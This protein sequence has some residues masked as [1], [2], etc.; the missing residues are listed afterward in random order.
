MIGNSVSKLRVALCALACVAWQQPATAETI[1]VTPDFWPVELSWTGQFAQTTYKGVWTAFLD[2]SGVLVVCG[3]GQLLDA[4]RAS[5][6]QKWIDS[7]Y[8]KLGNRKIL[9]GID[10]FTK[11][12]TT[13]QLGQAKATCQSTGVKP[14]KGET[15]V[16]MG[17]PPAQ[18]RF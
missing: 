7:V 9:K 14:Q 16:V 6:T 11:V 12:K 1:P 2:Q 4:S 17:A 8:V 5:A 10:F 13:E 18:A 3:A 15:S